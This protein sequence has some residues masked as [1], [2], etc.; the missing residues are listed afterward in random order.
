MHVGEWSVAE[1]HAMS[2]VAICLTNGF[3]ASHNDLIEEN[4]VTAC[5]LPEVLAKSFF[6]T[7][8]PVKLKLLVHCVLLAAVTVPT[9]KGHLACG[10][11]IGVGN[12][13]RPG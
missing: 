4:L 9:D 5:V 6:S 11:F 10:W 12:R 8:L 2:A 13:H 3:G 7:V 1:S